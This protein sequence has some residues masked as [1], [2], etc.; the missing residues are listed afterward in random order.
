LIELEVR[1]MALKK[2]DMKALAYINLGLIIF[3]ILVVIYIFY[4]KITYAL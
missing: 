4:E 1:Y 2:P 3:A